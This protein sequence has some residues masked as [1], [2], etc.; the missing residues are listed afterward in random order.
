MFCILK[1]EMLS[2]Q[3]TFSQDLHELNNINNKETK[4]SPNN[5]QNFLFLSK[6]TAFATLINENINRK[7]MLQ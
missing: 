4:T 1:K 6:L 2:T 3:F 5:S 7:I